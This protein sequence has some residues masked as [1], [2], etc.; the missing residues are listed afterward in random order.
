MLDDM[1]ILLNKDAATRAR[2]CMRPRVHTGHP[3]AMHPHCADD[4]Y[5]LTHASSVCRWALARVRVPL[6]HLCCPCQCM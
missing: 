4:V 1:V 2:D 6:R 3:S 5:S